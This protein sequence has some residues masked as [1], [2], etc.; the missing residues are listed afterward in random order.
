MKRRIAA[1]ATA[2]AMAVSLLAGCGGTAKEAA[3]SAAPAAESTAAASTASEV[4]A[5]EKDASVPPAATSN[6]A[7]GNEFVA[8]PLALPTGG[9]L[10]PITPA[11]TEEKDGEEIASMD[12]SMRAYTPSADS[13]IKNNA[14][15]FFYYE[16]LNSEQQAIYDAMMMVCEN[17]ADPENFGYYEC[18]DNPKE[19]DFLTN[20]YTAWY[21]MTLDHP[22]LFWLYM[23]SENDM[24]PYSECV[25]VNGVYPVYFALDHPFAEYEQQMTAFNN[26]ADAF[27][28]SINTSGSQVE[29]AQAIHDKLDDMITYDDEVAANENYGQ[30][31]AHTAYGALVTNSRGMANTAVCDG[32]SLAFVY[33]CQQCGIDAMLIGGMAG[34]DPSALGGHAWSLANLDGKWYEV[35]ACWDDAGAWVN[36]LNDALSSGQINQYTYD[37]YMEGVNDPTYGFKLGHYMYG[38]STA[39]IS[40][41][42]ADESCFFTTKDGNTFSLI[43]DSMRNRF[44]NA[45]DYGVQG[46]V[47][48]MAPQ[49]MDSLGN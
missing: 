20:Y 47:I 33:L 16:Q 15:S 26:A 9:F 12:R 39:Q 28:S 2:A 45:A 43:S 27:L 6:M 48:G 37:Q 1:I 13:L 4:G 7:S 14:E 10:P 44:D 18:P 22:E 17:P 36:V 11:E 25:E 35:D 29:V 34:S 5:A 38:I 24:I 32:Y 3:S 19:G 40:K 42:V 30:D 41:Y 46:A 23:T 8:A 21:A 49:A 31:L